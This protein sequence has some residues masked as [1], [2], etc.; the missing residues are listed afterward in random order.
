MN[1]VLLFGISFFLEIFM[2]L[3]YA[4]EESDDV[5]V[6]SLKTAEHSI[7]NISRNVGTVLL[8]ISARNVHHKR[9]RMT[10]SML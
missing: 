10:A 9:N 2:F 7:K 1:D 8:K 4:N 6:G 5:I 3:Y